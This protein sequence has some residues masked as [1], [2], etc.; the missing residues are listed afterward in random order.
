ML[1]IDY[2]IT[3]DLTMTVPHEVSHEYAIAAIRALLGG[4]SVLEIYMPPIANAARDI[5]RDGFRALLAESLFT[6]HVD[7]VRYGMHRSLVTSNKPLVTFGAPET[8][9]LKH[10][11]PLHSEVMKSETLVVAVND[12]DD[13]DMCARKRLWNKFMAALTA[14]CAGVEYLD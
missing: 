13:Q 8:E 10:K 14:D 7:M 11:H 2:F 3:I 4:S 6:N 5:G 1:K 12:G 9:E